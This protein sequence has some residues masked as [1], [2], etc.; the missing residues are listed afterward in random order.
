MQIV[1]QSLCMADAVCI[2]TRVTSLPPKEGG[3]VYGSGHPATSDATANLFRAELSARV[4]YPD[5]FF[6]DPL[7]P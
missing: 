3:H 7:S 2:K 1:P 5:L 4:G 6:R